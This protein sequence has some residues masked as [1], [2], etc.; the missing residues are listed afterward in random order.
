MSE[1]SQKHGF[2]IYNIFTSIFRASLTII[3]AKVKFG[4]LI[5]GIESAKA[6]I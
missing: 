4:A 5:Y 2:K 3:L 1:F 6:H